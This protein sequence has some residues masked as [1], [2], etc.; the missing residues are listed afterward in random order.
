MGYDMFVTT[1]YED[2]DCGPV[3]GRY[4]WMQVPDISQ[5]TDDDNGGLITDIDGDSCAGY[6][7]DFPFDCGY[8]DDDDFVAKEVCCV[9]GGG[10][11]HVDTGFYGMI[12]YDDD[13]NPAG[14]SQFE[15]DVEMW[16]VDAACSAAEFVRSMEWEFLDSGC[17][18][19]GTETDTGT[20]YHWHYQQR[21]SP[22]GST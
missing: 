19:Y 5:C 18:G 11:D 20:E 2:D 3:Y 12:Y 21:T 7:N 1:V 9:C 17:S 14:C 15:L 16:P 6:Y 4:I 13:M 22:P 8:Y 10:L